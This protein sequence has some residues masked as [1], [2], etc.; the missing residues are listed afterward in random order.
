M[1]DRTVW[2]LALV[3]AAIVMIGIG[4]FAVKGGLQVPLAIML[5]LPPLMLGR[6]AYERIDAA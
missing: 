2:T 6:H 1:S 3:L 4:W 5:A